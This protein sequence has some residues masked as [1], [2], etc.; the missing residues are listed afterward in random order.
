MSNVLFKL[1][2]FL[3]RYPIYKMTLGAL[4]TGSVLIQ[5]MLTGRKGI[6]IGSRV[7]IRKNTWLATA[8]HQKGASPRLLIGSGTYVGNFC[9][10]YSTS[11]VDIGE[12]VLF[13]DRVYVSDNSHTYEDVRLPVIDQPVR[14][15]KPVR[16]GYGSWIGENACV[17]GC[18]IGRNCVVGANTIVTFDVPDYCV[19]V[20]APAKII[21]RFDIENNKWRR[22]AADGK[23]L[24]D[25]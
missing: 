17:I 25:E 6:H 16:I 15:L 13:A 10:F 3:L 1:Y 9:H 21:K 19:V 22:T 24:D 11:L 18:T 23:F 12:K 7:F 5:P 4:G 20:G 2:Y 14:Q 8:C